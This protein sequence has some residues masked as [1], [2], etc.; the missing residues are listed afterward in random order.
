MRL[1]VGIA[2]TE[3]IRKSIAD[4]VLRLEKTLPEAPAKWV[5]PESLHVTLK[6]IGESQK[7]EEIQEQ[8]GAVRSAPISMRFRNVG[9]F[10]PRK[11]ICRSA[12]LRC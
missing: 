7:L 3:E 8:L 4:Y 10:T 1:F 2:I 5:K 9:F 11:R 12:R 6:F